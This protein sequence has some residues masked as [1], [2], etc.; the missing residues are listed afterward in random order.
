MKKYLS[1]VFAIILAVGFSAFTSIPKHKS[2]NLFWYEYSVASGIGAQIGSGR[3]DID[4][5]NGADKPDCPRETNKDCARGYDE[6]KQAGTFPTD[7]L[8]HLSLV[9]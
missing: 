9:Q 4:T 2:V 6:E 5:Y 7:D 8:D 1:G 3:I